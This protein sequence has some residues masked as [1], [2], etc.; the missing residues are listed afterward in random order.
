MI[1]RK[2]RHVR[3]R[4]AQKTLFTQK[5]NRMKTRI[6]VIGMRRFTSIDDGL[7]SSIDEGGRGAVGIQVNHVELRLRRAPFVH[8][9]AGMLT[10]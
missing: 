8:Q 6:I 3:A 2:N 1:S 4:N 9:R 5:V 7:H 10:I